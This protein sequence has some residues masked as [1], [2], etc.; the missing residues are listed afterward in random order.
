MLV[1]MTHAPNGPQ[2]SVAVLAYP[3][4][5][6]FELSCVVEVFGLPRPEFDLPWYALSVCAERPDPMPMVGGLTVSTPH[7]LDV[8]AASDTVVVPGVPDVRG[9]VSPDLITA[10]RTAYERG[11]R[12]V[13]I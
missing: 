5:A 1:E 6:P 12:I 4:M 3:G 9:S 2:H 11:S 13:S 10:L 8:L 7:G